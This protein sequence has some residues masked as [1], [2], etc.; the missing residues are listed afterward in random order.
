[1]NIQVEPQIRQSSRKTARTFIQVSIRES[2][3]KGKRK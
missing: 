3:A 2:A 1:M